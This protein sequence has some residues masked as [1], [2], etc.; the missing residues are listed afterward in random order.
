VRVKSKEEIEGEKEWR[1]GPSGLTWRESDVFD[2]ALETTVRRSEEAE[3]R[4]R[5]GKRHVKKTTA[6]PL[7]YS[8]ALSEKTT[9]RPLM[10][11]EALSEKTTARPL[12]YSEV[13]RNQS[14]KRKAEKREQEKAKK[15]KENDEFDAAIAEAGVV[16]A[17][18]VEEKK[19]VKKT[20]YYT[21]QKKL[22][23][24][25][26]L[27]KKKLKKRK[28]QWLDTGGILHRLLL[29]LLPTGIT[30]AGRRIGL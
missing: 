20:S 25:K 5:S 2:D 19:P 10:Y 24:G 3:I 28:R 11:S 9:A 7:M 16:L 15:S 29:P 18:Y 12:M 1:A 23:K 13:L 8:E 21:P 4:E 14:G 30:A 17:N 6:R 26:K 22:K 27:E